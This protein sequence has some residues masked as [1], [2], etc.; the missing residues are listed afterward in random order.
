MKNS[1]HKVKT[2]IYEGLGFPITL[3]NTPMRKVFGEWVID[4]DMTRLQLV[5]LRALAF[6]SG[7]LTKH[8]LQFIRKFLAL[9]TANFGRIFGVTHAA[10]I[11]WENGKRQLTPSTEFCIRLHVLSHLRA[12]ATEF[13]DLYN[14]VPLQVL[15]KEKTRKSTCLEIDI[16]EN[17]KVA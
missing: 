3:V 9:T 1:E 5:V 11:Q 4:I 14:A 6:K 17:F 8:E 15:A 10:V 12:K 16:S 7:R 13:R 2:F